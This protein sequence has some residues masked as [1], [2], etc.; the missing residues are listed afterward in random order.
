MPSTEG[1]VGSGGITVDQT[2]PTTFQNLPYPDYSSLLVRYIR[3]VQAGSDANVNSG[4]A[5][6]DATTALSVAQKVIRVAI[7]QPGVIP[8]S[9]DEQTYLYTLQYFGY[10]NNE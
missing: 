7:G 3:A 5:I 2:S 1:V 10:V 6:A 4:V 9:L 8:M